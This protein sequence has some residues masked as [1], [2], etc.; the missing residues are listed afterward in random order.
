MIGQ[1]RAQGV[2]LWLH[3]L[4]RESISNRAET[5]V[6][7]RSKSQSRKFQPQVQ[8]RGIFHQVPFSIE[9]VSQVSSC[10]PSTNIELLWYYGNSL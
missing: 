10:S 5:I 3:S 4:D 1:G 2:N 8:E 7:L 9:E 6:K